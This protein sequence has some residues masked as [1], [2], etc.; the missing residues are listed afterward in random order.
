LHVCDLLPNLTRDMADQYFRRFETD[1]AQFPLS[2]TAVELWNGTRLPVEMLGSPYFER[3]QLFALVQLLDITERKKRTI[4]CTRLPAS[5]RSPA[6]FNRHALSARLEQELAKAGRD[7]RECASCSLTW[8]NSSAST[9]LSAT[10]PATNCCAPPPAACTA[11]CAGGRAG[12]FRRRRVH[13]G[14]SR[15]AAGRRGANG[16]RLRQRHHRPMGRFELSY[17]VISV[18]ASIG[19]ACY[20]QHGSDSDSL[21]QRRHRH[22][23]GQESRPRRAACSTTP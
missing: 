14:H 2:D 11:C 7:G 5:T 8:T 1:G 6:F 22:V 17:H 10:P 4:C 12:P 21:P 16:G 9:I 3:G 19:I 15:P 23:R 20:P 13:R 18:T